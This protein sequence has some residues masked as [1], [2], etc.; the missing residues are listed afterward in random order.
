LQSAHPLLLLHWS[1]RPRAASRNC[2]ACETPIKLFVSN[3][4]RLQRAANDRESTQPAR[5][6]G[7]HPGTQADT[8]EMQQMAFFEI[9]VGLGQQQLVT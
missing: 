8:V 3:T 5:Q 4:K 6:A 7:R 2:V 9:Y 1:P